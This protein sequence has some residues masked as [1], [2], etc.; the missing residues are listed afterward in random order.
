MAALERNFGLTAMS[1]VMNIFLFNSS[2]FQNV[3]IKNNIL[4]KSF[5]DVNVIIGKGDNC[6]SIATEIKISSSQ[7]NIS[8]YY[9]ERD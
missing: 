7:K 9:K 1:S 6:V 8:I 4:R 5:F 2:F 3:H